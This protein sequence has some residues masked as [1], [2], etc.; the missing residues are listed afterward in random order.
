MDLDHVP[1][2]L[3]PRVAFLELA[4]L[5]Q[6][7]LPKLVARLK[8]NDRLLGL[9]TLA[10]AA[11]R[12]IALVAEGDMIDAFAAQGI[13]IKSHPWRWL[14][15][16]TRAALRALAAEYEAMLAEPAEVASAG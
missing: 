12:T 5:A 10:D 13:E 7:R 4:P 1:A 2:H 3:Q 6:R 8:G 16:G 11:Q 14:R 9:R 15:E